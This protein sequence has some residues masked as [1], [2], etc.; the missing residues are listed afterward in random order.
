MASVRFMRHETESPVASSGSGGPL[1]ADRVSRAGT[2]YEVVRR[3]DEKKM[4]T[5]WGFGLIT[6]GLLVLLLSLLREPTLPEAGLSISAGMLVAGFILVLE[7]RLVRDIGKATGEAAATVAESKASEVATKVAD[8]STAE[9]KDRVKHLENV[10]KL[11][12][13][14][15]AD[16]HTS[17]SLMIAKVREEPDFDSTAE[18]LEDAENRQLFRDIRLRAGSDQDSL[19]SLEWKAGFRP[20]P[21]ETADPDWSTLELMEFDLDEIW[22]SAV[23][24]AGEESALTCWSPGETVEEAWNNFL[25]ACERDGLAPSKFDLPALLDRLVESYAAM[26]EAR[27]S[28]EGSPRRMQGR[29]RMLVNDEWAITDEGLESRQGYHVLRSRPEGTAPCLKGHDE[30]LWQEAIIYSRLLIES[31]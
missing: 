1:R 6:G 3:S 26:T 17:V 2:V 10:Q 23:T 30:Q 21:A 24:A 11:Q 22:L 28:P 19:M 29:L 4:A 12:S 9:I 25:D 16:R 18:L 14:I 27:R 5:I 15:A 13:K 31:W 20:N 8:E 7:R